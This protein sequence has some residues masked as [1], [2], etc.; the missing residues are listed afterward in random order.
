MKKGLLLI[1]LFSFT[2]WGEMDPDSEEYQKF[3]QEL[4][5][6]KEYQEL[7]ASHFEMPFVSFAGGS[8]KDMV[9]SYEKGVKLV[10]NKLPDSS[11]KRGLQTYL[12]V[13]NA[14]AYEGDNSVGSG[15]SSFVRYNQNTLEE[16]SCL[17]KLAEAFYKEVDNQDMSFHQKHENFR[18]K[19]GL[20]G[21]PNFSVESGKGMFEELKPGWLMDKAMKYANGDPNLAYDLLGICG[22]DDTMQ[23]DLFYTGDAPIKSEAER[24]KYLKVLDSEISTLQDDPVFVEKLK[25]FRQKV[26]LGEVKFNHRKRSI[27]CPTMSSTFYLSKAL[28]EGVDL[29]QEFKENIAKVQ[30]PTLGKKVIPSK[31]YHFI[32][33]GVM[34]CKLVSKGVSPKMA[35]MIQTLGGWGYRTI[36]MNDMLGAKLDKGEELNKE[37][38]SYVKDFHSATAEKVKTARGTRKIKQKAPNFEEWMAEHRPEILQENNP[39]LDD[40]PF[41]KLVESAK[42]WR[43]GIDAAFLLD[44]MTLGGDV[45]G[46]SLPQTNLTLNFVNDPVTQFVKL[47]ARDPKNKRRRSPIRAGW[48]K[49]RFEEAKRKAVSYIADWNWTVKQHQIGAEFAS[50]HCE[51]KPQDYQATQAA[52]AAFEGMPGLTC[53]IDYSAEQIHPDSLFSL[54]SPLGEISDVLN[55]NYLEPNLSMEENKSELK[56][57]GLY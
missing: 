26:K 7:L 12:D 53:E 37:Y 15:N 1:F 4:Q 21:R 23:G 55:E 2:A 14:E 28:G 56:F 51:K 13:I 8:G 36:R 22:H 38:E 19:V 17:G 27:I 18:D 11:L 10:M 45:L 20:L 25:D 39:E 33:S 6:T 5:S 16:N 30:A 24:E 46:I 31:N 35:Q 42:K 48:E 49:E 34:A 50:K 47:E 32:A 29:P 41:A 43:V 44:E 52:C 3:L 9:G 57:Q 54:L 40:A